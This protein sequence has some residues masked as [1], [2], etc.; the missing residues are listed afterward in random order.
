MVRVGRTSIWYAERVERAREEVRRPLG[1]GAR[2]LTLQT[3]ILEPDG[4]ERRRRD[5]RAH[6]CV[7]ASS[8]NR[9]VNA[10]ANQ[11]Q[12]PHKEKIHVRNTKDGTQSTFRQ[13]E[14]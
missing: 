12:T 11:R 2:D 13:R 6:S 5:L 1:P 3:V 9:P 14:G 10:N 4:E 8:T 7:P